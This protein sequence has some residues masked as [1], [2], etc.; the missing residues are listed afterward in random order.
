MSASQKKLQEFY[1]TALKILESYEYK[2]L[3]SY[4]A[5]DLNIAYQ[6]INYADN[7]LKNEP[8]VLNITVTRSDASNFVI[9]G[10]IH[11]DLKKL[12]DIFRK[13]GYPPQTRYL[14]LGDYVNKGENSC[15]VMILLYSLKCMYPNHIFL[16]RGNH[17][18]KTMTDKYGFK[19]ECMR[20]IPKANYDPNNSEKFYAQITDTFASLPICAIIN[21]DIFCVHSG[22][23]SFLDSR[24]DLLKIHKI[25]H[26]FTFYD[27]IQYEFLWNHPSN[28]TKF[29]EPSPNGIQSIFGIEALNSFLEK[30]RFKWVFRVHQSETITYQYP[31]GENVMIL[32]IFGFYE[33]FR[34]SPLEPF[35][36][37]DWF[38][39]LFGFDEEIESVYKNL[40]VV[41]YE[42]HVDL[43]SKVNNKTYNTGLFQIKTSDRSSFNIQENRNGGKLHVIHGYGSNSVCGELIDILSMQSLPKW[44]GATY[45][46]ASN[47]NCLEFV[48]H[49]QTASHGVTR[50]YADI[51]QGPYAA[52]ACG[53]SI[54]YR[55][56]FVD[57]DPLSG[58]IIYEKVEQSQ[59]KSGQVIRG[60]INKEINLLDKARIP[61]THGYAIIKRDDDIKHFQEIP[62]KQ[63]KLESTYSN[64]N[65]NKIE[66]NSMYSNFNANKIESNSMYSNFNANKIESNSMY[67]NF[68]ANKLNDPTIWK[69]GVHRNCQVVLNRGPRNSFCLAPPNQTANHVYAAA[70]NFVSDVIRSDLTYKVAKQ[71][72]IGEY[73]ATILSAWEN[74]LLYPDRA[75]ANKLSLTLLGGGVFANPMDIICDAIK[76]NIQLIKESGLDVYITCFNDSTFRSVYYYLA[77]SIKETGGKI[78][79][80]NSRESCKELL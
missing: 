5:F 48:S 36:P 34:T 6:I 66:S 56:Y 39:K 40:D 20:R 80:T 46:A 67:S 47:F 54:V 19:S 26:E 61:V 78:Y 51:T 68:N 22:I 27:Q 11:G 43:V 41:K 16:T 28:D 76:E 17:E 33:Y 1:Q 38:Q 72:L 32:T 71:L 63:H 3:N 2:H 10:D 4:I 23:A 55:N 70:F 30:L 12:L 45:L 44:N 25:G 50:Y 60:Q 37:S 52:L 42:D 21:D 8:S 57:R 13:E 9:S 24:E 77:G 64:F 29:Y 14:F 75:G 58:Q 15:E 69:V 18:F 59:I 31:L 35:Y 74:S 79:D 7:L 53:P 62:Q 65:A 73:R 49:G